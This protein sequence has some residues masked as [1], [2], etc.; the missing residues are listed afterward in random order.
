[1]SNKSLPE[2]DNDQNFDLIAFNNEQGQ[3]HGKEI[4]WVMKQ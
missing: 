4:C 3:L 2:G 1:M